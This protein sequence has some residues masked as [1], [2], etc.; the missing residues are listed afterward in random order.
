VDEY[1]IPLRSRDAGDDSR[2]QVP[3]NIQMEPTRRWSHAIM[4]MRRAAHLTR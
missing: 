2:F 3:A 4:S 1:E